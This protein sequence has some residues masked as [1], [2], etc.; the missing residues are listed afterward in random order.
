MAL[1]ERACPLP[2]ADAPRARATDTAGG[3]Q[4]VGHGASGYVAHRVVDRVLLVP[5]GL[6]GCEYDIGRC[7]HRFGADS[8]P[9]RAGPPGPFPSHCDVFRRSARLAPCTDAQAA[10]KERIISQLNLYRYLA[11][12]DN[13]VQSGGE[14]PAGMVNPMY[15]Q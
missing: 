11:G 2:R 4:K 6:R 14:F 15:K 3:L 8:D 12:F 5:P 9:R 7:R 10:D 13:V 1:G